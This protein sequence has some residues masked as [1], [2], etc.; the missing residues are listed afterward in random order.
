VAQT[1]PVA[2]DW[3]AQD[4]GAQD[5]G[6]PRSRLAVLGWAGRRS[7]GHPGAQ[8]SVDLLPTGA[9]PATVDLSETGLAASST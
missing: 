8:R 4:W 1:G 3:G 6:A 7:E 9:G 2:Q 5:W